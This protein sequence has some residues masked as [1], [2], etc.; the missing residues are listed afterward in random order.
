MC[1][2]HQMRNT[3]FM[4]SIDNKQIQK[5]KLA[6]QDFISE[7]IYFEEISAVYIKEIFKDI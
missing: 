5:T 4:Y 3:Y 6:W 1:H 2:K 7:S